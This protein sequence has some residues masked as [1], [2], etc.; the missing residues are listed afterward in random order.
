M[1]L[2]L[3]LMASIEALPSPISFSKSAMSNGRRIIQATWPAFAPD[4]VLLPLPDFL[5]ANNTLDDLIGGVFGGADVPFVDFGSPDAPHTFYASDGK[6]R[7]AGNMQI[8]RVPEPAS[9]SLMVMGI[10]GMGAMRKKRKSLLAS[11]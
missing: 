4:W 5:I 9:I 10:V 1:I 11:R 6:V 7:V 2:Y 3:Q 8:A